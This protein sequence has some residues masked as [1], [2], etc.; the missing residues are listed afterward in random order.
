MIKERF[1]NFSCKIFF[2]RRKCFE[3]SVEIVVWRIVEENLEFNVFLIFVFYG[4]YYGLYGG[5][6]VRFSGIIEICNVN[7]IWSE[8]NVEFSGDGFVDFFFWSFK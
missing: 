8:I 3:E 6:S 5:E 1:W 2:S 4:I 7:E